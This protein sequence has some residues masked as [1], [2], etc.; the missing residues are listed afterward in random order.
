[1]QFIVFLP[2]GI[3]G[4]V[5]WWIAI[6]SGFSQNARGFVRNSGRIDQNFQ[7]E[8]PAYLHVYKD[9]SFL[10]W[11]GYAR[12]RDKRI[13]CILC[14]SMWNKNRP[15]MVTIHTCLR[16]ALPWRGLR[17][18]FIHWNKGCYCYSR[19]P[20]CLNVGARINAVGYCTALCAGSSVFDSRKTQ[21]GVLME[22]GNDRTAG[23][24]IVS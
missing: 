20:V 8:V 18:A 24:R 11:T 6:G 1:M 16:A 19:S 3:V 7:N 9:L 17:I 15:K 10:R 14:S 22:G 21:N 5:H 23:F 13:T 4:G 12:F 2:C